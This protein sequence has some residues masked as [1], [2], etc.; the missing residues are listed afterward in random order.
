MSIC[1][2]TLEKTNPSTRVETPRM[3][4]HCQT[5][6]EFDPTSQTTEFDSQQTIC[7]SGV[8]NS[9]NLID[10]KHRQR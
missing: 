2:L 4:Q 7:W 6:M 9:S 10:W 1:Q 8:K 3:M 5:G